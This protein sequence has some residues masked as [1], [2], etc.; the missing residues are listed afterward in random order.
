ML[1]A[2]E[3][4]WAMTS[5]TTVFT[6]CRVFVKKIVGLKRMAELH[7]RIACTK[8]LTFLG[9]MKYKGTNCWAKLVGLKTCVI[10]KNVYA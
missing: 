9:V 1:K 5:S 8:D 7:V 3:T 4:V 2:N 10:I 6:D